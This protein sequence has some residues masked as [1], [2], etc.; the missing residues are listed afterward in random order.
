MSTP[1]PAPVSA[2][3][4]MDSHT[5][6]AM[7]VRRGRDSL[8]G[9]DTFGVVA[10]LTREPIM[11]Q[12]PHQWEHPTPSDSSSAP[13]KVPTHWAQHRWDGSVPAQKVPLPAEHS[14]PWGPPSGGSASVWESLT[15]ST[16]Q[17]RSCPAHSE[18]TLPAEHSRP[19][20]PPGGSSGLHRCLSHLACSNSAGP[21]PSTE[22]LPTVP[23]LPTQHRHPAKWV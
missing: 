1:L 17:T 13:T 16:A 23:D 20:D 3:Q 9:M 8:A 22:S 19:R 12:Q 5:V 11:Q 10:W 6:A 14:S 4:A 7:S 2:R 21:L 18:G 15:P